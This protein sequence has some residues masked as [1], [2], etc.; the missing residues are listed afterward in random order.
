MKHLKK[1]SKF[2]KKGKIKL[3]LYAGEKPGIFS[4]IVKKNSPAPTDAILIKR[5]DDI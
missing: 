2:R 4:P 1:F 5:L 3:P